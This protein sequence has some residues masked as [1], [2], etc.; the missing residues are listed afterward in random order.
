[1]NLRHKFLLILIVILAAFLRLWNINQIP[2]G[3]NA[4]EAALGYNAYSLMTTGKD[5]YGTPFPIHLK[6]FADYKPAASAYL[7]IP[8]IKI[9]GLTELAVRMP[10]LLFG[11]LAIV[12]IFML[13]QELFKITTISLISSFLLA[14]SPWHIQFSRGAW[15]TNIATTLI[16]AG[17]LMFFKGLKKPAYY[18]GWIFFFVLSLYTYHA[19]RIVA[20]LLSLF[21]ILNYWKQIISNRKY[22]LFAIFIGLIICIPLIRDLTGP[23]VSARFSGVGVFSDIG[24]FWQT[25]RQRGEDTNPGSLIV[26]IYHNKASAYGIK[27]LQNWLSHYSGNFLFIDGDPLKRNNIPFMG[28]MYYFDLLFLLLG[29]YF[30]FRSWTKNYL[31]IIFWLLIAPLAS[32]LTFQVPSALRAHNLIIPLVIISSYGFYHL[33]NLIK[34]IRYFSIFLFVALLSFMAWNISY[35]L[36]QYYN[37]YSRAYPDAWEY[38][39][40][41]VTSYLETIQSKVPK[42]YITDKYDQ[43]YILFLFYLQYPPE[44]FQKEA[45][46]SPRDKFGFST[47][48]NFSNYH[49]EKINWDSLKNSQNLIACGAPDEIP[50]EKIV[51]EQT[52]IKSYHETKFINNETAFRCVQM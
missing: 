25:N 3:F 47:V 6:S 29:I 44:L 52:E 2:A 39:F 26:K 33:L 15:E 49:F 5:E 12:L 22:I 17:S 43:P 40:Q 11:V 51:R 13:C 24:P 28:E 1:M 38:G 50:E 10:S 19:A 48:R 14:I 42:I 9:F 21:F 31:F 23:A 20:P 18:L 7:T 30:L 37:H 27:L 45:L 46:L 4:D 16:L 36:H 34:N 32:T 8:F 35:Y 41:D